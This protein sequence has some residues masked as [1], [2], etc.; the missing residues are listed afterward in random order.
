MQTDG[1]T[2]RVEKNYC[3]LINK[4]NEL[5]FIIFVIMTNNE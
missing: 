5:L 1:N 4:S 3:H 2:N